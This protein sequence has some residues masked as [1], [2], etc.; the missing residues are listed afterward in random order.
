MNTDTRTA[1]QITEGTWIVRFIAKHS[2]TPGLIARQAWT[3]LDMDSPFPDTAVYEMGFS[4]SKEHNGTTL[5]SVERI[6]KIEG[7]SDFSPAKAW[8]VDKSGNVID[9][10]KWW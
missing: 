8:R 5:D 2:P 10:F 6:A 3:K 1:D 7:F 4:I 9:T